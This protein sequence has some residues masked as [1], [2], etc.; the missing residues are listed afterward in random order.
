MS[1]LVAFLLLQQTTPIDS[2]LAAR[3]F[4]E[5]KAISQ[6]DGGKLWNM[7]VYAPMIFVDPNTKH[8]VANEADGEGRMQKHGDVWVGTLPDDFIVANSA[9]RWGGT[10]WTMVKWPLP[11]N[12]YARRRLMMHELYHRM[13]D[14]LKLPAFDVANNHLASGDGRVLMRLEWRA[15]AEALMREGEERKGA[16]AD[17]VMFRARRRELFKEAAIDERKLELNE[18]LAEYTGFKLSGLPARVLD[19]RVAV[20]LSNYEAMENFARSFAYA[21]GPAYGLLLDAVSADWRKRLTQNS[22]LAEMTRAAYGIAVQNTTQL[23]DRIAFYDAQ[24]MVSEER[25]R[26]AQRLAAEKKMR[27][28]LVDGPTL[29]L[30]VGNE[31]S[32]GFDPNGAIP[33][34]GLGTAYHN[35]TVTDEWGSLTVEGGGALLLRNERGITGV[36]VAAPPDSSVPHV[37]KGWKL[38][39][40]NG[41]RVAPSERPGSFRVIE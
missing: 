15:L 9:T 5:A 35:L 13:Q 32:Y 41:W 2:E 17:A 4:A 31:F 3:Y 8:A 11:E 39:L 18:G 33:L 36:V 22:D 28:A 12:R 21:S 23:D 20:H 34:E 19:D 27:A 26:A 6:A 30:P 10:H 40:N 25:G 24:R 16:I 29:S 14:S 38:K 37:G 1:F 7:P